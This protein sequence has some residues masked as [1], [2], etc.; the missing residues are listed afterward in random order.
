MAPTLSPSAT[1]LPA[2]CSRCPAQLAAL[3]LGKGL[4]G[5][6]VLDR[7]YL[8]PVDGIGIFPSSTG[9]CEQCCEKRHRHSQVTYY[10]QMLGTNC[11]SMNVP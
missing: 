8:L 5:Y 1:K 2:L 3:Q 9:R 4:E 11:E 10:H 7:H 6:E